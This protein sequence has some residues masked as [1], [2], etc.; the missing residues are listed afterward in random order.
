M[1]GLDQGKNYHN[2]ADAD[3]LEQK[4]LTAVQQAIDMQGTL[5]HT[6]VHGVIVGIARSG[7]DSLMKRLLGEK[8]TGK[9]PSTG[10]AE[11]AVVV[12]VEKSSSNTVSACVEDSKW[13]RLTEYDDEAIEM[14]VQLTSKQKI[15]KSTQKETDTQRKN[16]HAYKQRETEVCSN[17][18]LTHSKPSESDSPDFTPM[19]KR[20]IMAPLERK[21]PIEIFKEALEKRGLQGLRQ[22]LE[23]HWSIYL[24]NTGGQMEFQ[25]LLPLL[26]SGP[27]MFFVTF[28]LDRDL[29]QHYKIKY[30]VTVDSSDGSHPK[31]FKYTSNATPL[32]TILQT[33]AS[34]DAVG[35][36]EYSNQN[37]ERTALIYK[38]FIVGTHRDWLERN[39]SNTQAVQSKIKEIN[40]ILY[41]SVKSASYFPNIIKLPGDQVIFTV[42]NFSTS[43]DDFKRIRSSVEQEVNKGDFAMTSPSHWLIYSLVLRQLK[44]QIESYDNCYRIAKDCRIT[45]DN[46]FKEALHFIHTKMGIIR[47]FPVDD[48]KNIVILDPQVLFDKVTELIVETFTS[49]HTD[50]QSVKDFKKGIFSFSEFEKISHRRNPD[51]LLTPKRFARLLEHLRIAAPFYENCRRTKRKILKYFFPCALSHVDELQEQSTVTDCGCIPPL[52]ISFECSYRPMGLTGAL[53]KYLMTNERGSKDFK[54]KLLTEEIYRDQ[55]SFGVKPYHDTITLKMFPTHIEV[56]CL[57]RSDNSSRHQDCLIEKMCIEVC[58]TIKAGIEMVNSDINYINNTEP[59]FTFYCQL[60]S[61]CP[62]F[63]HHPA[64][65]ECFQNNPIKL[66]CLETDK[67]HDLPPGHEVWQLSELMTPIGADDSTQIPLNIGTG[68]SIAPVPATQPS[69]R[70]VTRC[71][72]HHHAILYDQLKLHA[73]K[74]RDIGTYLGFIKGELDNIQDAPKHHY[75][76]PE[77]WLGAMLSEWLQWAPSAQRGSDH[78]ATLEALKDAVSKAGFGSTAESLSI[79]DTSHSVARGAL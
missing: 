38:V 32:E 21:S 63:K 3:K 44:S 19:A 34:I 7:K 71:D 22:H 52:V 58:K 56:T 16:T 25:E 17:A 24:S 57:P 11:K 4:H 61:S 26:V 53:I 49:E 20:P 30:K 14:M 46:E 28:R 67:P 48:L 13:T 76:A 77:S 50:H 69:L 59:L 15:Q 10:V 37:R 68:K 29:K 40:Q 65:L 42:D 79:S 62:R 55:V 33:L 2:S 23:N 6:T 60:C 78:Y 45:D 70:Q 41:D 31:I 74:W 47:Y 35:T 39:L 51:P 12:R 18:D 8:P 75:T 43:D 66:Y 5:A 72:S 36:Y 27:S 9:S 73:S 64:E 1:C 54:W